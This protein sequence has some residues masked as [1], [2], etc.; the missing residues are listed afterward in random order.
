M[1]WTLSYASETF[2]AIEGYELSLFEIVD[3]LAPTPNDVVEIRDTHIGKGL[4]AVRPYPANAVIGEITGKLIHSKSY[5]SNYAFEFDDGV[6]LEPVEPFRYV[7]HSCEPNCEFD[8][9]DSP[10]GTTN[11]SALPGRLYLIALRPIETGEEFSIDYNWSAKH[12]IRCECGA[13][14]C[15]GWVVGEEE[16]PKITDSEGD[17]TSSSP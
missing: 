3:E 4:F 16:L 17:A 6:M 8:L 9:I 13:V 2:D 5:G 15:R 12:A 14:R 1:K 7:N 11:D 10:D